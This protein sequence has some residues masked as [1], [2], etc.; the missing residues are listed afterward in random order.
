M[1]YAV[2]GDV[3]ANLEALEAVLADAG[4]RGAERY[5][6]TGDLVGYNADP[7][8]CMDRLQKAGAACVQ[9]NHDA[10]A[11]SSE[12]L[13]DFTAPARRSIEWTRLHLDLAHRQRLAALPL[14]L[15]TGDITLVHASLFRPEDWAYIFT[16]AE[17]A[18][19]LMMQQ[20]PVCF[21]GHTHR[22][23]AFRMRNGRIEGF[24]HQKLI[25]TPDS[26]YLINP[27]SIGQPR[28]GDPRAA[29]VLYD[30]DAQ[31]VELRRVNYDMAAAQSKI[32]AAGLPAWNADRLAIGR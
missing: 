2:F 18:P 6:C 4:Q 31:T 13:S 3:H 14:I 8:A 32:R 20:T 27:G 9:G 26:R 10:F 24:L 23:A 22:P 5:L 7:A 21:Y 28:D 19:G 15:G 16:A 30:D 17:A 11:A 25:L 12:E 29:Y 1:K